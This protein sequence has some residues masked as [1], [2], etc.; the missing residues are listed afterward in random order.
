MTTTPSTPS[1]LVTATDVLAGV[2][3]TGRRALV[4]GGSSGLGVEIGRALAVAG[5]EVTLAVR[6]VAAGRRVADQIAQAGGR[7][8][9]RVLELDLMSP[10]SIAAAA[11]S[12]SGPLHVLVANAGI[13]VPP[14]VRTAEGWESQ[15]MTNYLGHFALVTRLF[16]A[17]VAAGDARVVLSSS[18]AH[19]LGPVDVDAIAAQ[20][21][22][23]E[24]W[25]AYA[26]S[27]TAMILFA[28]EAQRRWAADG[29]HVS[30]YNPGFVLTNL[31]KNLPPEMSVSTA[32]TKSVEELRC[33]CSSRPR[34]TLLRSRAS[35]SRT[36]GKPRPRSKGDGT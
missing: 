24:P 10:H 16:P 21:T 29:V 27:K 17:L 30:A 31:Q 13:M 7:V 23:Y 4:T 15:F 14:E 11:A 3:L 28:V 35:T 1:A 18:N 34:R 8:P 19:L 2:D 9:A 32:S 36:C 12:W 20:T 5:A 22:A 26:V 6:D 25:S 33:R